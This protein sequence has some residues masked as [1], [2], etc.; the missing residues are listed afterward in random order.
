MRYMLE[1]VATISVAPSRVAVN[2]NW[3]AAGERA[4]QAIALLLRGEGKIAAVSVK[5]AGGASGVGGVMS[6]DSA[7]PRYEPDQSAASAVVAGHP[8]ATRAIAVNKLM[9]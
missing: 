2:A 9:R 7:V 3:L 1:P 4:N 6:A 5:C 8:V